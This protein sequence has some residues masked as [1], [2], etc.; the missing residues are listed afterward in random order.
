MS[1]H[2]VENENGQ[3]R[4]SGGLLGVLRLEMTSRTSL[5]AMK[6][7]SLGCQAA[8]CSFG[9]VNGQF[10]SSGGLSW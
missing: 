6:M 9:S 10:G 7:D 8:F 5:L 1:P 3:F 4:N 2:R